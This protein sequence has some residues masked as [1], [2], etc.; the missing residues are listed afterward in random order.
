MLLICLLCFASFQ[1]LEIKE[2]ALAAH[3]YN[4]RTMEAKAGGSQ[5]ESLGC[6]VTDGLRGKKQL[7]IKYF[8]LVIKTIKREGMYR[9]C[10]SLLGHDLTKKKK[11]VI[12]IV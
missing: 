8:V 11:I 4:H 7:E 9:N 2:P 3:V 12:L 10:F 1:V 5:V 6:M